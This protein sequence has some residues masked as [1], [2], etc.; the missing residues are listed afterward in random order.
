[1]NG[2]HRSFH[3]QIPT[4][5][6][7]WPSRRARSAHEW[8]AL[9]RSELSKENLADVQLQFLLVEGRTFPYTESYKLRAS[10]LARL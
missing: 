1:M 5:N 6:L 10:A 9:M 2:C 3:S 7:C 4:R 8:P